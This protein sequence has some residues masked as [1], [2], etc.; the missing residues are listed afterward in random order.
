MNLIHI[1]CGKIFKS[2]KKEKKKSP[3]FKTLKAMDL[4]NL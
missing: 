1:K 3:A 4:S 2:S